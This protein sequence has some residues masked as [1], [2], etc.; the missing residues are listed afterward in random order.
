MAE[1]GE[2]V[3]EDRL[4]KEQ[5]WMRNQAL[6]AA[7]EAP[8]CQTQAWLQEAAEVEERCWRIRAMVEARP[9]HPCPS[10]EMEEV[11][12]ERWCRSLEGHFLSAVVVFQCYQICRRQEYVASL[13]RC[14]D[15]W[16]LS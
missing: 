10:Q 4:M 6:E 13:I 16:C 2:A 3:V 15:A 8:M 14:S 9:C 5:N 12:E 11:A 1:E 7:A